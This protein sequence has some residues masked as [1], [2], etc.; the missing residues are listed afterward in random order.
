[1]QAKLLESEL[2]LLARENEEIKEKLRSSRE[3]GQEI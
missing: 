1:L 3:R 2:S